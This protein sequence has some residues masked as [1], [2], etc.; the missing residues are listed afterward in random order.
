MSKRSINPPLSIRLRRESRQRGVILIF[1]LV[2]LLI[3]GIG[4]VALIRSFDT[5]TVN[6]VNL[7]FKRDLTSEGSLVI[8][9]AKIWFS[10]SAKLGSLVNQQSNNSA[11]NYSAVIV[12]SDEHGIPTVLLTTNPGSA[13]KFTTT[14][15][16]SGITIYFVIDRQ[17]ATGTGAISIDS[18][19]FHVYTT[20]PGGGSL[21]ESRVSGYVQAV[22]RITIRVDGPHDTH[23]FL[24]QTVAD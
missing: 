8:D 23:T 5:S 21:W 22:F 9:Q 12:P 15:A 16:L 7:A 14:S 3:L 2:A 4:A 6:A 19:A 24:Q 13:Y 11:Y 18:C 20:D 10:D 1:A 17:C